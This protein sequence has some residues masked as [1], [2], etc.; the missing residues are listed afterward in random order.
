[1]AC[2]NFDSATHHCLDTHGSNLEVAGSRLVIPA[3]KILDDYGSDVMC[4]E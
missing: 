3:D 1:M 4:P 2:K